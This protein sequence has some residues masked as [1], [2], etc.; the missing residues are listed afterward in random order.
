MNVVPI[1]F[2]FDNNIITAACVCLSSLM[3]NASEETFY[4]I[5]VLHSKKEDLK[6][7]NLNKIL[8]VYPNCQIHYIKVD[9]SF[10]S[11]Y[12]VRHVTKATYYR[13]ILPELINKYDKII[14]SDVDIV[15]RMD[16]W[17]VYRQDLTGYYLAATYDLGLNQNIKYLKSL[18]LEKWQYFQAGFIVMNLKELR[19]DLMVDKFKAF[20]QSNYRYQDQD[21]INISCRGRIK[22]LAPCYNVNDCA[23]IYIYWHRDMLPE[24]ITEND[25]NYA[26]ANG[27]LHYSGYKPWNRYSIGFDIWWE[28]Y[29]KSPIYDEKAYFKFFF[30]KTML[31][32]SLTLWKRIKI[33]LR[34]FIHGRYK[35]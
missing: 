20:S 16:L 18:G 28:Y 9:D 3:M 7:G 24:T 31:L 2:A 25:F 19:E 34:F 5:F 21:I 30:N 14:Y 27:N 13:L 32:D 22:L 35:G 12:E 4:D 17:D 26:A 29:R 6:K 23:L 15:F 8:Q 10:D 1:A 33:L 11:A